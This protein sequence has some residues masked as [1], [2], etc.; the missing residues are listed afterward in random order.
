MTTQQ[1]FVRI[2]RPSDGVVVLT[3]D[4]SPVNALSAQARAEFLRA[5]SDAESDERARVLVVTGTG[6]AF[7]AGADLQELSA[8]DPADEAPV[9]D[10]LTDFAA[11]V[12][13]VEA[14]RFPVVA[15]VNG[16]CHGGG[17]ELALGCD[18]RVA[19]SAA[20]F[21][22]SGVN[23]GL[24]ASF[25]RLPRVIGAGWARHLLLTGERWDAERA[26][27]AGLVTDVHDPHE[28]LPAAQA[29]AEQIASRAPLSVEATKEAVHRAAGLDD[30]GVARLHLE[31]F[32]RLRRSRDHVEA[33]AAMSERRAPR[34]TR[35]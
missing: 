22:C 5:L 8:Q 2:T 27:Q 7:S 35:G 24:L 14:A 25:A 16:H 32:L 15:A 21:V 10:F 26:L 33:L 34:F 20:T 30:D 18:I 11:L 29:L 9:R 31:A 4:R 12:D 28:L 19:S 23:V 3:L 6:R 13:R 1:R 17:L